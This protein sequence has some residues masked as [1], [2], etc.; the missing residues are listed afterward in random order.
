MTTL[1]DLLN[2]GEA[3]LAAIEGI[4]LAEQTKLHNEVTELFDKALRQLAEHIEP[5]IPACLHQYID[6]NWP[7]PEIGQQPPYWNHNI[8]I[9][10]P[11]FLEIN[12]GVTIDKKSGTWILT[13]RPFSVANPHVGVY[14]NVRLSYDR[15]D[16]VLETGDIEIALI[17]AY[18]R[19]G[20]YSKLIAEEKE[21]MR[22]RDEYATQEKERIEAE[23]VRRMAFQNTPEGKLIDAVTDYVKYVAA[24]GRDFSAF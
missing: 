14:G 19:G 3:K 13:E 24:G 1:Q 2:S 10:V 6:W 4:E 17:I 7:V 8:Y 15:Q 12:I 9:R 5:V 11:D 16:G 21:N 20:V 22:K 18:V 23:W